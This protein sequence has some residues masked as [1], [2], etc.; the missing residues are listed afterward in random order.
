M[1]ITLATPSLLFP[2]ISLLLLAYT[3]RFLGLAS[4]VRALHAAH[5]AAP[6]EIY[7]QQIQNLRTRLKMI[8]TMQFLGV[9]SILLCTVAM[10]CLFLGWLEAG[11]ATF[12]A[13]LLFMIA[14]LI[15]SAWEIQI[16]VRALDVQLKDIERSEKGRGIFT[17]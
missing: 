9:V 5:T 16:S 4:V 12:G 10:F 11:K 15:V 3:N 17:R 2:A 6:H 1:E 7:V 14:S 8:R 13:S